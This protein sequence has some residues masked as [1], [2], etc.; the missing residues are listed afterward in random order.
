MIIKKID[1]TVCCKYTIYHIIS[2][3][4]DHDHSAL[5]HEINIYTLRISKQK[6]KEHILPLE[7]IRCDLIR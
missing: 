6:V 3:V 4:I 2:A 1:S 5:T 7:R